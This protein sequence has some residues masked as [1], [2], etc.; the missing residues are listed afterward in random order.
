M[1]VDENKA[2]IRRYYEE[3][4]NEGRK[5]LVDEL[6]SPEITFRGSLGPRARGVEAF[7]DYMDM[8]RGSF[9][10][11]RN[12]IEDLIGEG[13]K[14]VARLT[15]HGTHRGGDVLFGSAAIGQEI[16]YPGISIFRLEDG[17]IVDVWVVG[18]VLSLMRQ[19]AAGQT[20]GP[21]S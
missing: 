11:F 20:L 8:V 15:H 7:K 3:L 5:E 13:D 14:V 18:D 19:L 4:W 6:L 12:T 1:T 21:W 17:R 16:S 9:P 2:I 10:D